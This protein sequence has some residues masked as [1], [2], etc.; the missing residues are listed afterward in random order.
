MLIHV[1]DIT[2]D[3]TVIKNKEVKIS[4]QP[5]CFKRTLMEHGSGV[6]KSQH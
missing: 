1:R 5:Y 4:I 3:D 2:L 6:A